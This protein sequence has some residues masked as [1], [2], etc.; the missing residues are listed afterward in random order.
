LLGACLLGSLAAYVALAVVLGS[1]PEG[2]AGAIG[3]S[4]ASGPMFRAFSKLPAVSLSP[5]DFGHALGATMIALWVFWGG[6]ALALRGI[7]SPLGRRRARVIVAAGVVSFLAIVVLLVPPVLS[8]DLYRQAIYGRMVLRGLNPYALSAAAATGDPL[9]PLASFPNVTTSY[10]PAYTWLSAL[11]SAFARVTPLQAALAWKATAALAALGGA[12][13]AGP[14]ARALAGEPAAEDGL[15]AQ[16]W[17]GWSPLVVV[18]SAGSGHVEAIM[19]FPALAGILLFA[20]RRPVGGVLALVVSAL[21]KWVTGVLLFL[22]TLREIRQDAPERR[23]GAL[24]RLGGGAALLVAVLYA[25]FARG[26]AR[27]GGIQDLAAHGQGALGGG[28]SA[29]IPQWAMSLGFGLLVLAVAPLA[30]SGDRARVVAVTT[31]LMLVFVVIVMPWLF[32]WYFAAPVA[33]AAVLPRDRTGRSLRLAA[34]GLGAAV[35]LY[36][37]KPKL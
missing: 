5:A 24:L 15:G 21:T 35:M 30:T 4:L 9:L 25:P 1:I 33:L 17:L 18:E 6:A 36:Y 16:L 14:V 32:P 3:F 31:A 7:E 26:F 37:A 23:L 27:G 20:R 8:A 19:M 2:W 10:G 11:A 12:A 29:A 22:A 13:V 34:M 28:A